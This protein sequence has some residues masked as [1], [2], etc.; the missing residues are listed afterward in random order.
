MVFM[1]KYADQIKALR[2]EESYLAL[3]NQYFDHITSLSYPSTSITG[4]ALDYSLK[5]KS[6]LMTYLKDGNILWIIT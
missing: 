6:G 1:N 2:N 5:N 3:L 4:K